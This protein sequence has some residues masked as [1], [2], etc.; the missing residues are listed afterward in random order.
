M[1]QARER[2]ALLRGEADYQLQVIYLWYE[3]KPARAVELLEQLDRRYP[4]N[5]LFV[6][7]VAEVKDNLNRGK[8]N[9]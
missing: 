7:R 2:G 5:P 6:R 8:D 1:L 4:F 9:K 3:R